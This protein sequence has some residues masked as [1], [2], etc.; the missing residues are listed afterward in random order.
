MHIHPFAYTN[1][2]QFRA[3]AEAAV[4]V[5]CPEAQEVTYID[6]GTDN[7]VALVDQ[8][9]T[10]HFPRTISAAKR[11]DYHATVLKTIGAHIHTTAIPRIIAVHNEYVISRYVPG[12]HYAE[13]VINR[14]SERAQYALGKGLA[15][16]IAEFSRAVEPAE[17]NHL[18]IQ[19]GLDGLRDSWDSHFE[20]L[21]VTEMLPDRS[22]QP[23]LETYYSLWKE[24]TAQEQDH[25]VIHD[26]L[27]GSNL[28]F[29]DDA[30][31][32]IVD[33]GET[34]IGSIEEEMR[35]LYPL[36]D[37]VFN[38]LLA[39]YER[40]TGTSIQADHV[41]TWLILQQLATFIR[42]L[43]AGDTSS[44]HFLRAQNGL[45]QL[46]PDFPL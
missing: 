18:R 39:E 26:D 24:Y 32:G 37:T 38:A 21:F 6:H 1:D 25:F 41:R 46:I 12:T 33:F 40:L 7:L 20:R 13:A 22:L 36:G 34:T 3:Q 16:F 2:S 17:I 27:H 29:L 28:L 43:K 9:Y 30:L 31:S 11:L 19:A 42:R 4:R 23:V 45:R 15:A 5:I 10:F 44:S 14:M 35:W 8:Q